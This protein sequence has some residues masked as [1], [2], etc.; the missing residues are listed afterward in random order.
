MQLM[1]HAHASHHIG[2][3]MPVRE[4]DARGAASVLTGSAETAQSE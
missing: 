2:P 1:P 4:A 3:K